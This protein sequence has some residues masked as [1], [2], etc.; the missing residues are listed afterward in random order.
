MHFFNTYLKKQ[1][2]FKNEF[3]KAVI[4]I[5]NKGLNVIDEREISDDEKDAFNIGNIFSKYHDYY[6]TNT[7][8][9]GKINNLRIK[10][11]DLFIYE[12][13]TNGKGHKT[14]EF[15]GILEIIELPINYNGF[16]ILEKKEI[17]RQNKY[18]KYENQIDKELSKNFNFYTD[19]IND[20]TTF[21]SKDIIKMINVFYNTCK[22]PLYMTI[23]DNKLYIGFDNRRGF[24]KKLCLSKINTKNINTIICNFNQVWEFTENFINHI[25]QD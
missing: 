21:F 23:K 4:P 17:F 18:M 15:E 12:V 7:Y 6:H 24:T 5:Y 25:M 10:L 3:L 9:E 16:A 8:S 20:A 2:A 1:V 13:S 19:N 14:T 22:T 11:A